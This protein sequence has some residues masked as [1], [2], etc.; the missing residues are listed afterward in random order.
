MFSETV[1]GGKFAVGEKISKPIKSSAR[2]QTGC[3]AARENH[4]GKSYVNLT[5]HCIPNTMFKN[6]L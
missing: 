3:Q 4:L 2:R 5:N 1:H 6:I